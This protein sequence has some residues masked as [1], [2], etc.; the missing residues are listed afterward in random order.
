MRAG[1]AI[2]CKRSRRGRAE[3]GMLF[4]EAVNMADLKVSSGVGNESRGFKR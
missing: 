4:R 1:R 2:F 3:L